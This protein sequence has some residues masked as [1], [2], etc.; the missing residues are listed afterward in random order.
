M[1]SWPLLDLQKASRP[2]NRA[3]RDTETWLLTDLPICSGN[4]TWPRT[5]FPRRLLVTNTPR[6]PSLISQFPT[7]F[8]LTLHFTAVSWIRRLGH[9]LVCGHRLLL[10]GL[11][12][13]THSS[14]G[15]HDALHRRSLQRLRT[16]QPSQQCVGCHR[17]LAVRPLTASSGSTWRHTERWRT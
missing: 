4:H 12:T 15:R 2:V 5:A 1:A 3:H 9:T 10:S 17:S 8:F 6:S 16:K 13:L 7:L 11:S 14:A